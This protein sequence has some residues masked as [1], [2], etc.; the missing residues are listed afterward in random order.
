MPYS[1]SGVTERNY[2]GTGLIVDA[3]RGLVVTD[4]NTVP[5]AVGDVRITF[6][7]TIEVPG[8]GR[9]HPSAAQP[10]GGFL[11]PGTD[12]RHAGA[13]RQ[14]QHHGAAAGRG[15]VGDRPALRPQGDVAGD[16][17]SPRSTRSSSRCRARCNSATAISRPSAWSI[18]PTDY[19]GVLV[20]KA[21]RRRRPVVELCV[22][23]RTR[24]A[25]GEPRRAGGARQRDD[26]GGDGRAA[27]LF[28]RGGVPAGAA[29][30]GQQAGLDK[31]WIEKLEAARSEAPAGA[32]G[33]AAGRRLARR[34]Q[35]LQPGDLLLAIDGQIVNRF[36]EVERAV[37]KSTVNADRLAQRCARTSVDVNTVP[38]DGRDIDRVLIWAGATLQA[39]HRAM[40]AQRGIPPEGV[41]VAY[42]YYGSP[43][44]RYGLYAGRRIIE[45]DGQPTPDL[46]SFIRAVAGREDRCFG[47]PQDR[48]P[49]T[50]PSK[51]SR[52]SSTST[53][54]RLTSCGAAPMAGTR[55]R[56]G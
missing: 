9:V 49:G 34:L 17:R 31:E 11:R 23:E 48:S 35:Q 28:A 3:E 44:T 26:P 42:F 36:R 1:V 4:R 53:T 2:H 37:Q 33:R 41:F 16:R 51:S 50:T 56:S 15:R 25:A 22:R 43:A 32:G 47:A 6:A 10:G 52:S 5:V 13:R 29:R 54:G 38:L 12:R 8:Q 18:R 30:R 39:P 24:A 45:V 21:G 55:A 14:A 40:A 27:A 7:G 46:D 19:D 20:N